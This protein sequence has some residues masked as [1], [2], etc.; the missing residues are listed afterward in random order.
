MPSQSRKHR[1]MRTQKV[2]AE[3]LAANGW[4]FAE[5]TGS[6]R[7]GS[8]LT[9]VPG[10]AVEIK[11]RA[12]FDPAGWVRQAVL[13]PGLPMVMFRPNGM[14]EVSVPS[15]PVIMRLADVIDLLHAA[16]YGTRPQPGQ[17]DAATPPPAAQNPQPGT[18]G[19]PTDSVPAK[20]VPVETTQETK[21]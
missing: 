10:L 13:N 21:P 1:G 17:E 11:A 20:H 14:G 2:I 8:D 6:G 3:H 19:P 15:W 9:G 16:G 7:S 5:S 18:S 12:N 4:P